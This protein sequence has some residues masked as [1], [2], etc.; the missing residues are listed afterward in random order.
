MELTAKQVWEMVKDLPERDSV[1]EAT[2]L[3]PTVGKTS[4]R[5]CLFTYAGKAVKTANALALIVDAA[6]R[7]MGED[8][9]GSMV[10]RDTWT[11]SVVLGGYEDA[12]DADTEA[13]A[14]LAA[15]KA[16]KEGR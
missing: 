5:C 9:K 12:I 2:G 7:E 16:W 3:V 6:K 10:M 4:G 14:V 13:A 15:F 8:Y 11:A 1:V